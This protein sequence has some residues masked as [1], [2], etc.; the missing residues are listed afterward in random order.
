MD[1]T[2]ALH[3]SKWRY[4][5]VAALAYDYGQPHRD[6]ELVAA[7]RIA[8]DAGVPVTFTRVLGLNDGLLSGVSDHRDGCGINRAFVPG[9][10]MVF[11]SL[12]LSHAVGR[13]PLGDFDVVIG[14]CAE[15]SRG[16][17]DCRRE[18]FRAAEK[19]LSAALD[20]S[21]GVVAPFIKMTKAEALESADLRFPGAIDA[22]VSSW[23]CYRG[24]GPC[25]TCSAC[26]LRDRA[27]AA[28]GLTDRCADPVMRGGDVH[29]TR[30]LGG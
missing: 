25:G 5:D 19:A 23:S 1:S 14:A 6:A 21:V 8:A 30:R 29:R 11:L 17:P 22:A 4:Q 9:R 27:F 16:F 3:W 10:N 2:L 26:V 24:K 12:A 28:R 20:R 15:D 13:W 7:E 18:F